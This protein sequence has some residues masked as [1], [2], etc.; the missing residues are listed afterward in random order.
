MSKLFKAATFPS[1]FN[2][3]YQI[4]GE[5][6]IPREKSRKNGLLSTHHSHKWKDLFSFQLKDS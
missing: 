4:K 3:L 6:N 1:A 2:C 5:K